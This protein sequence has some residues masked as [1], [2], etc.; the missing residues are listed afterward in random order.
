[1]VSIVQYI[2]HRSQSFILHPI[3]PRVRCRASLFGDCRAVS[4]CR[5]SVGRCSGST[6]LSPEAS[7]P[8]QVMPMSCSQTALS[9]DG[10]GSALPQILSES[11]LPLN[12]GGGGTRRQKRPPSPGSPGSHFEMKSDHLTILATVARGLE[13]AILVIDSTGLPCLG[14]HRRGQIGIHVKPDYLP[15]DSYFPNECSLIVS[16]DLERRF[17]ENQI[18]RRIR[19]QTGHPKQTFCDIDRP[20]HRWPSAIL[21]RLP[22]SV[23]NL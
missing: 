11:I 20:V 5:I 8:V 9:G 16:L 22:S 17:R 6:S 21:F 13:N 7:A 10:A 12:W 23:P 18:R 2:A 3:I 19:W 14:F 1:M 15:T 4:V